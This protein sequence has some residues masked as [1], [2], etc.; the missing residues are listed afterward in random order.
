MP[1]PT[2]LRI[3]IV[4]FGSAG[5]SSAILLSRQGHQVSL[6]ERAP[7]NAPIGA[8]FLLQPTGLSVLK[9]LGIYD[10]LLT[11]TTEIDHLLCVN[12]SGSE[13]LNLHYAELHPD[14][15]GQGTHRSTLFKLLEE[16]LDQTEANLHWGC[17]ILGISNHNNEIRLT[18]HTDKQHGPFDLLVIADGARSQLRKFSGI[19]VKQNRYPWG[20]LWFVGKRTPAFKNNQLWQSVSSTDELCG[21][22]PTGTQ[23]DLLSLFWSIR[24]DQIDQWRNQPLD[25]WKH[26]VL[27]LAPQSES[28]LDQIEHHNDLDVASYHDVVMPHWH[29]GR[30]VVLGD[31]AHALSPQLGQGVNL[32]LLDASVL[33]K[34]IASHPIEEALKCFSQQRRC[35]LG[36]YQFATRT[37]TPFFQ[38]DHHLLGTI[39][40]CTF[41]LA[42]KIPWLRKQMVSTMAGIKTGLFTRTSPTKYL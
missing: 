11:T 41:P 24:L 2:K 4:G 32:A 16:T 27:K 21:F 13:I 9:E 40:D 6:F 17:E 28:F 8:G 34:T 7:A 18:D 15:K 3:A 33:A 23:D 36:F 31:A 10:S 1:T 39:R 22:L 20:A 29:Q 30:T 38:S 19:P 5:A 26:A 35:Q 37:A 42:N 12:D 14:F 25:E